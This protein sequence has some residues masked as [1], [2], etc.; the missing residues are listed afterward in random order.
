[1]KKEC[2]KYIEW[3]KWNPNHKAKAVTEELVGETSS[4]DSY[5][6]FTVRGTETDS[7]WYIDSGAT[8]HMC[9]DKSFFTVCDPEQNRTVTLANSKVL[10]TAGIGEGYLHCA[11]ASGKSRKI[12]LTDV[13]YVPELNGNLISVKKLTSKGFKVNF[14]ADRTDR[15]RLFALDVTHQALSAVDRVKPE[16]IHVWHNRLGTL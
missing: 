4:S 12:K 15:S 11:T 9:S 5:A 7:F 6:C 16:C 14:R 2:R 3:K 1:M 13:L 10:R 8:A